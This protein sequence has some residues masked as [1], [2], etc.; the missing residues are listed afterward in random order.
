MLPASPLLAVVLWSSLTSN[1]V[2]LPVPA[3]EYDPFIHGLPGWKPWFGIGPVVRPILE[4]QAEY[5]LVLCCYVNTVDQGG[6]FRLKKLADAKNKGVDVAQADPPEESVPTTG[7]KGWNPLFGKGPIMFHR[8]PQSSAGTSTASA[9]GQP[10]GTPAKE[11]DADAVL[12]YGL[13]P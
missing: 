4:H 3:K 7:I 5:D 1:V 10:V 11:S 8:R 6:Y 2:A 13:G 12:P 9:E